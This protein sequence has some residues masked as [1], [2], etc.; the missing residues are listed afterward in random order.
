MPKLR[1][2]KGIA[3]WDEKLQKWVSEENIITDPT[4]TT[5]TGPLALPLDGRR[6]VL[7]TST[8][9][10]VADGGDLQGV[11]TPQGDMQ[12]DSTQ[13]DMLQGDVP[14]PLVNTW[15]VATMQEGVP[16]PPMANMQEGVPAPQ[17]AITWRGNVSTSLGNA[18]GQ[19]RQ[20][21]GTPGNVSTSPT[22]MPTCPTPTTVRRLRMGTSAVEGGGLV[23]AHPRVNFSP[24]PSQPL[25]L[26]FL[27][28]FSPQPSQPVLESQIAECERCGHGTCHRRVCTGA[29][30]DMEDLVAQE[31]PMS[32]DR[33]PGGGGA[34]CAS[35]IFWGGKPI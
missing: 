20:Q 10:H 2:S 13:V 7:P 9:S 17:M 19:L 24:S 4:P 18:T 21:A 28:R 34:K 6:G 11:Q 12:V 5:S 25:R 29:C 8:A 16:T 1:K 33:T 30:R 32:L 35:A 15:Q 27:T 23:M 3:M 22:A 31:T 14:T 26:P